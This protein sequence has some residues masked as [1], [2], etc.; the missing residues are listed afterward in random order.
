MLPRTRSS[1]D[2]FFV[3]EHLAGWTALHIASRRGDVRMVQYLR[4]RCAGVVVD[5][6]DFAG[7]TAR[8]VAKHTPAARLFANDGGNDE[9]SDSDDD[10][11]IYF[12]LLCF[13]LMHSHF[14]DFPNHDRSTYYN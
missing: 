5:A 12:Y 7:R 8:R 4:E 13:F 1:Y 2:F 14:I 6:K 11:R 3:Q 9:E 10:V